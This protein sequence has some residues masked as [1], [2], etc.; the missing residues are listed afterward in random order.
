MSVSKAAQKVVLD[1]CQLC[2]VSWTESKA[3]EKIRAFRADGRDSDGTVSAVELANMMSAVYGT[4]LLSDYASEHM[5][6]VAQKT[7]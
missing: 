1:L 4:V 2:D 7:L 6:E 5:A 3:T